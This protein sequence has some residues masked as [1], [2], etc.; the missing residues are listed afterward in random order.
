MIEVRQT[1]VFSTWLMELRDMRARALI[2][3]RIDRLELGNVGDAK[4]VGEGISEMRIMDPVI[5]FTLVGEVP[6]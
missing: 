5:A 1:D 4:P 3:A 6:N 2:Q